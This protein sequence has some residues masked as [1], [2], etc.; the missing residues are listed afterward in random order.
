MYPVVKTS[1][2]MKTMTTFEKIKELLD[3]K[4]RIIELQDQKIQVLERHIKN[5]KDLVDNHINVDMM[6]KK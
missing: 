4:T 6:K 2:P 5:L 3:S 1:N